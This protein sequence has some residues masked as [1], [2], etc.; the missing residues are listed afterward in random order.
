VTPEMT[1]SGIMTIFCVLVEARF[2]TFC[3]EVYPQADFS[4]LPFFFR[5]IFSYET[6]RFV[7]LVADFKALSASFWLFILRA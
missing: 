5:L 6:A 7:D 1:G 4:L 3:L 2:L